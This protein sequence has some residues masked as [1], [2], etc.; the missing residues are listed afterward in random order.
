MKK[1]KGNKRKANKRKKI[2]KGDK[3]TELQKDINKKLESSQELPAQYSLPLS[4]EFDIISPP[5]PRK[6][7]QKKSS[8][9][10]NTVSNTSKKFRDL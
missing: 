9:N 8:E 2:N 6:I 7:P 10:I 1:R 5:S 3:G 4:H